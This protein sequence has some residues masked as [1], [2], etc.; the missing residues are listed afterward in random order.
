LVSASERTPFLNTR[1]PTRPFSVLVGFFEI[2][3]ETA[4]MIWFIFCLVDD[5]TVSSSVSQRGGLG[6]CGL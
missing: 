4:G 2:V 3:G 5:C 6:C 1:A